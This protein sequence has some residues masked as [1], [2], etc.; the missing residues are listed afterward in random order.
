MDM[1]MT[2][3]H[4]LGWIWP[5]LVFGA[6]AWIAWPPT[7]SLL[8]G[9]GEAEKIARPLYTAGEIDETEYRDRLIALRQQ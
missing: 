9:S 3:M 1:M 5:I 6:I 7:R 4:A 8:D 2:V